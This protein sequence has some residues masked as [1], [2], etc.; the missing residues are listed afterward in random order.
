MPSADRGKKAESKLSAYFRQLSSRME[1]IFLRLPDAHGGSATAKPSDF[2][3][4][5]SGLLYVIECKSTL[6]NYRLPHGNVDAAQIGRMRRWEMAGASSWL[7]VYHEALDLWRLRHVDYFLNRIGGSW[8]FR[9]DGD[10]PVTL[11]NL[12]KE[13]HEKTNN[14]K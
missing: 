2:L 12:F 14:L 10:D 4:L 5:H 8:D 1:Y 6:H 9:V 11:Q 3:F 7:L 13:L